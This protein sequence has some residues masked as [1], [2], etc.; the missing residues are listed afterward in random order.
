MRTIGVVTGGRSDYGCLVP[1]LREIEKTP[2]LGLRLFVTGMHLEKA[3]GETV[4]TIEAD[5][6][7][8]EERIPLSLSSDDPSA[9]VRA[10]GQAL[11]GFAGVFKRLRPDLLLLLGDRFEMQAAALSALPFKIPVAHVHGGEISRG[12]MDDPLRHSITK[13]SHLHFAATEVYARRLLQMG[14]E[15]WRVIV[16]GAPALDHCRE[17]SFLGKGELEKR[18]GVSLAVPPLLVT[19]HPVTL[20]YE[21]TGDQVGELF[22]TLEALQHPV[23][24]TAPNADTSH[25]VIQKGIENFTKRHA[26][27]SWFVSNLGTRAY[28]SMMKLA[29]AM[30]GNSSSGIVEAPSFALPVVNIGTRQEGRLRSEN[31]IDV[32]YSRQEITAGIQRA[33]SPSFRMR[34]SGMANP[35]GDGQAAQRI[36]KQLAQISITQDLIAKRFVD[37]M[38]EVPEGV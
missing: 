33:L 28:F 30:V 3:F 36:V 2:G 5:G 4:R 29:A 24:F 12:A 17:V 26:A 21:K 34:L 35:Y 14:E 19:Y 38:A 9:I 8:I 22:A 27:W 23:L 37:L 15:P 32:G 10:M 31:V 16:S 20:E 25:G 6:F 13:L 7:P 18:L 11:A 1:I